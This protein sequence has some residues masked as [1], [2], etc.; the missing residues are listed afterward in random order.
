MTGCSYDGQSTA[1]ASDRR[2]FFA[3]QGPIAAR[4]GADAHPG[5]F[6]AGC[7]R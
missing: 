4:R 3:R 1:A 5:A 7:G 6:V 2:L